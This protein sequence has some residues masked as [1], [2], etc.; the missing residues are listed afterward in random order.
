[1][2]VA[3]STRLRYDSHPTSNDG[4]S[5]GVPRRVHT[6]VPLFALCGLQR[7]QP[8]LGTTL[9]KTKGGA[10]QQSPLG[11]RLL[12]RHAGGWVVIGCA[13]VSPLHVWSCWTWAFDCAARR[14]SLDRLKG[15][16]LDAG[17]NGH[18]TH[19][20]FA[21]PA[22]TCSTAT[23]LAAISSTEIWQM[24]DQR[25]L[26]LELQP[27][28]GSTPPNPYLPRSPHPAC[29]SSQS[30]PLAV[31]QERPSTLAPHA[32]ACIHRLVRCTLPS[33]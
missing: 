23:T 21:T 28:G 14:H 33:Y 8:S 29:R 25:A 15:R 1:M 2:G 20:P 12:E 4:P 32:S 30:L 26:Y 9:H 7:K 31:Y 27:S 24:T 16:M 19:P 17:Q 10:L 11:R 3:V 18:S 6:V 22:L 13:R 5:Y